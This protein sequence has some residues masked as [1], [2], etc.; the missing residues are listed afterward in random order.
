[1]DANIQSIFQQHFSAYTESHRLPLDQHKAA[2][3]IMV[4]GTPAMG[5]HIEHCP[6]DDYE[7]RQHHSCRHRSCPRCNN[8][9][10]TDWLDKVEQRLLP[11]EHFHVI[12]TLPHELN[13]LWLYNHRWFTEQLFKVVSEVLKQ[14]LKEGRHLG[15][16]AGILLSLHSWGR[17]LSLHPHIHALVTAG[18]LRGSE[19]IKSK[20]GYLVPVQI[21]KAVYRGKWLAALNQARKEK[22]LQLPPDWTED[23]WRS[24]LR[25]IARKEWNIRI[26]N[27]YGHGTGVAVYLSRYVR[28]GPLKNTQITRVDESNVSFRYHDHATGQGREMC[29]KVDDFISRVLRHVAV[30]GMHNVRYYG[31]YVPNATEKRERAMRLMEQRQVAPKCRVVKAKKARQCPYCGQALRRGQNIARTQISYIKNK[32]HGSVQQ[33]VEADP[34]DPCA[35]PVKSPGVLLCV[36]GPLN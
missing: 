36:S 18:G 31:L 22:T 4:C 9:L 24:M 13:V 32:W 15:A 34:V 3:A 25:V 8:A 29:L 1:M 23:R 12:F 11:V 19:W 17:N 10:K 2:H 20:S 14:L 35:S 33:V 26:Q 16:E 28:G 6:D 21:L 27:R 30:A 5:G 7:V